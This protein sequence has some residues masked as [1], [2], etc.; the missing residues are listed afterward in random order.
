G[1]RGIRAEPGSH[2]YT[3]AHTDARP[4]DGDPDPHANTDDDA[5]PDDD[6]DPDDNAHADDHVDAD[7]DQHAGAEQLPVQPVACLGYA[8]YRFWQRS[9]RGGAGR[10]G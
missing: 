7:D 1:R 2:G 10:K 9:E 8:G 3:H 5:D 6:V 4:A